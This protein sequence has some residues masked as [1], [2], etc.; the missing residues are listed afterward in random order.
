M[1]PGIKV[2]L[3]FLKG[4]HF[5]LN[6]LLPLFLSESLAIKSDEFALHFLD[7]LLSFS[8]EELF[9]G[10]LEFRALLHELWCDKLFFLDSLVVE[11][12]PKINFNISL[13]HTYL[14]IGLALN[15]INQIVPA[16]I[17]NIDRVP[18]REARIVR[19]FLL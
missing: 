3:L 13:D 14:V 12:L 5:L 10:N 16:L 15:D 1:L 6:Q 9:L 19:Q 7:F 8:L 11:G 4:I 17:L 18:L 2:L